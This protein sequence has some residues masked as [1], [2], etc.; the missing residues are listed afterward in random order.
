[1]NA[2]RRFGPVVLVGLVVGSV[3]SAV[4]PPEAGPV[5]FVNTRTVRLPFEVEDL[6]PAGVGSVELYVRPAGRAWRKATEGQVVA[7]VRG[8]RGS[9]LYT[10]PDDGEYGF[11]VV[12]SNP[13]GLAGQA[14]PA[15]GTAPQLRVVIDSRPP[16]AELYAPVV[17]GDPAERR[18]TLTWKAT[19][20]HLADKPV[21]LAY[22]AKMDGP[23]L[24]IVTDGDNTGK[25]AWSV[26]KDAP[27]QVFLRLTVA[28]KAGNK[29]T[30]YNSAPLTV[31]FP[32]PKVK[33]LGVEPVAEA[34]P[35]R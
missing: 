27:T 11:A 32:R 30:L 19:D 2:A 12:V 17:E 18:L 1:M 31:D 16:E 29:A 8:N 25:H 3:A 6:G 5:P 33:L 13:A 34:Y 15:E 28:D 9:V 21:A 14:A 24:P 10:A 23:W 35:P 20:A 4:A 7:S 22:A 26:P